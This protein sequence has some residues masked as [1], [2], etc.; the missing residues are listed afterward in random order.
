[1]GP[2]RHRVDSLYSIGSA[3]LRAGYNHLAYIKSCTVP[4]RYCR[5]RLARPNSQACTRITMQPEV[6]VIVPVRAHFERCLKKAGA[7][8]DPR[9]PARAPRFARVKMKNKPTV[10]SNG[11]VVQIKE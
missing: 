6:S 2:V 1:M 11:M 3:F 8:R 4:K 5:D 7:T 9:A 10:M